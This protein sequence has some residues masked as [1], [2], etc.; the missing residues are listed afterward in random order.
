MTGELQMP[1]QDAICVIAEDDAER[2]GI[3]KVLANSAYLVK[4]YNTGA[5]F[6]R[7]LGTLDA[8]L[9]LID[10]NVP[11][12]YVL[13]LIGKLWR[14]RPDIPCIVMASRSNALLNMEAVKIGAKDFI[15]KPVDEAALLTLVRQTISRR[16][17]GA[18]V[19]VPRMSSGLMARLTPREREVLALLLDG[20]QNKQIAYEL[21]ISQRTVEVYRARIM[22][23][24][25]VASFAELVRA[26]VAEDFTWRLGPHSGPATH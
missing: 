15:E 16:P 13:G 1:D 7:D 6:V 23:R 8:S 10:V 19:A 5:T 20:C 14:Q 12:G 26:A 21:A 4:K 25:N 18:S 2:A 3:A 9:V 17:R 11:D 22:R 24:L